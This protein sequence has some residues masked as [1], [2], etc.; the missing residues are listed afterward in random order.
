MGR[1]QRDVWTFTVDGKR[2]DIGPG[3]TIHIPRGAVHGFTN[4]GSE[5]A[6]ILSIS[7]PAHFSPDYFREM[8]A[9]MNAAGD[10]PPDRAAIAEIMKRHGLTPAVPV[11]A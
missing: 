11:N 1:D 8:A 6:E 9:L 7:T 5:E 10:A 3:E 2:V 4:R